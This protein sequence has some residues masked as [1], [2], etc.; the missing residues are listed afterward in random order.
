MARVV[1]VVALIQRPGRYVLGIAGVVALPVSLT[2]EGISMNALRLAY[3]VN[4][5]ILLPIALPTLLRWYA[6]DQERFVESAGW[7][8]TVGAVWTAI[9]LLSL[10]GLA[11][12]V[13][14][15]P[16]LLLQ[17]VYKSLWLLVYALPRWRRGQAHAVPWGIAASFGV[18]VLLWP[19]LL[20]WRALLGG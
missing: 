9:L 6:T 15:A 19:W 7:R 11:Q 2:C 17:W 18:I 5:L 12:P 4:V 20:P 8:V 3:V 13:R 10:L 16:V 14:Y 1:S